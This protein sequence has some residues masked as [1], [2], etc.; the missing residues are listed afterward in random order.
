M[1]QVTLQRELKVFLRLCQSDLPLVRIYSAFCT[2]STLE[3]RNPDGKQ[4]EFEDNKP[5]E[6]IK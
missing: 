5:D 3:S 1:D 4:F 2:E 6:D